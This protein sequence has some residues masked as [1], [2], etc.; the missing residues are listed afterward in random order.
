MS[1]AGKLTLTNAA[2]TADV[3][4]VA[5]GGTAFSSY[6]IGDLLQ[7]SASGT[8]AKLLAVATGNVLLSGGVGVA[9]AWGKVGLATHVSG[10]LPVTNLNSGTS[11]GA[12]TFWRGDGTWGTPAGT[13][14]GTVTHTIG[15]LT[16]NQLVIGNGTDDITILGT[17]GTTTTLLHGNA[18]GAPTFGAV[19]LTADVTGTLPVANGGTSLTTLTANNVILGNG[20]SAPTFV[21]PS[22]SG[23]V[24]TSNGST[25]TSA[26]AGAGAI[27]S[28]SNSDGTLTISP[29]T[30][31]V[32]ASIALGHANRWTGIQDFTTY[33][34]FYHSVGPTLC[35][36]MGSAKDSGIVGAGTDELFIQYADDFYVRNSGGVTVLFFGESDSRNV[37]FWTETEFG[38]GNGVIGI[39]NTV[40]APSTTPS[41]GGVLYVQAGA[42]KYKGSSGTVTTIANA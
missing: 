16:A 2:W 27:S 26:A 1:T 41:G 3:V 5:Y 11:A 42:L 23:N 18:A 22:T 15:A 30:G 8:L 14:T 33:A 19:S 13:G 24:L 20:T 35:G 32:V 40:S 17:L 25:W 28:V 37:G 9:S 10:N 29:T 39:A 34:R 31:A 12:T 38:S 6:T 21:A 7:A 36:Y 4:G